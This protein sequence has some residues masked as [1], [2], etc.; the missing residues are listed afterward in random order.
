MGV[1]TGIT[2]SIK[3]S[4]HRV[5][6]W[7][8]QRRTENR[9]E[10]MLLTVTSDCSPLKELE[11]I[12]TLKSGNLAHG[13]LAQERLGLVR[14]EVHVIGGDVDLQAT[15]RGDGLDL[16]G[17]SSQSRLNPKPCA[18]M[19]ERT[20]LPLGWVSLVYRVPIDDILKRCREE[21]ERR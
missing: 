7:T 16:V 17:Y 6:H 4:S 10:L 18:L 2:E 12:C 9:T 21:E 5:G 11:P 19:P 13:E 3:I 20:I 14:L 1:K 15:D 8:S